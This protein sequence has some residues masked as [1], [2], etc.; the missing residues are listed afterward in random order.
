MSEVTN[1][2]LLSIKSKFFEMIRDGKKTWEYRKVVPT[3]K[4]EGIIFYCPEKND[5]CSFHKLEKIII[6]EPKTIV[7]DCLDNPKLAESL[8][9][10][11]GKRKKVVAFKLSTNL[12]FESGKKAAFEKNAQTKFKA[13][14]SFMY[15]EMNHPLINILGIS[16]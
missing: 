16:T 4:V 8:L 9:R 7:R 13:P 12:F 11:F 3:K 2:L 6:D 15:I 14:Q 5:F 10:Y 1:F